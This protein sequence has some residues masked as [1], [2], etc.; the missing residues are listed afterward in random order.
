MF[1]VDMRSITVADRHNLLRVVVTF[2][3]LINLQLYA[4]IPTA[5]AIKDWIGFVVIILNPAITFKT[6]ITIVAVRI[7]VITVAVVSIVCVNNPAAANASI[8]MVVVAG[9]A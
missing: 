6:A 4:K 9:V 8:L 1:A 2:T 3:G 5:V 7:V